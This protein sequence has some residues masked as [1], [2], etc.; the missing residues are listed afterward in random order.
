MSFKICYIW[1]EEFRNFSNYGLNLN[2]EHRFDFDRKSFELFKYET[3]LKL[4]DFFGKNVSD[5]VGFIGKNGTGKSNLLELIC[6]LTKGGKTSV[7]SDF[8]IITKSEDKFECFYRFREFKNIKANFPISFINYSGDVD[9]LKVI[10]FSNIYDERNHSFSRKVSD[11]SA[12]KRYRRKVYNRKT[13]DFVKQF[14]FIRSEF[15]E[16]TEIPSPEKIII[17]PKYNT[18]N[19]S[20]FDKKYLDNSEINNKFTNNL[21]SFNNDIRRLEP[22]KDKLYYFIICALINEVSKLI[23]GVLNDSFYYESELESIVESSMNDIEQI[24]LTYKNKYDV[25]LIWKN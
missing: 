23:L 19:S 11:L 7:K 13:S 12:N 3:G 15:F 1:I 22:S 10:Y 17:H 6:Q 4:D 9:K 2:S 24:E 21:R 18:Y 25:A 16:K 8:L 5:V 14:Q 20:F